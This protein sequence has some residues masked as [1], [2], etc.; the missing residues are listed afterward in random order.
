VGTRVGRPLPRLLGLLAAALTLAAAAALPANADAVPSKTGGTRTENGAAVGVG[1][2]T[3]IPKSG[4]KAHRGKGIRSTECR[5]QALDSANPLGAQ[6]PEVTGIRRLDPG[7]NL[8]RSCYNI[9]TGALVEG[10]A[11]YTTPVRNPAEPAVGFDTI[12]LALANIDIDLPVPALSPPAVTLPNFDT[13]LWVDGQADQTA[14]AAAGGVTVTVTG[15]VVSTTYL[16]NPAADGTR[17]RDDGRVISCDGPGTPYDLA[18]ADRSQSSD[19]AH[20][21]A[22]PTRSFTIDVTSTWRLAW[23]ATDGSGGDLGAIDRTTTVP[24]R[25]QAKSTA[26][27]TR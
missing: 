15:E 6:G 24:Y 16:I 25:V 18:V 7:I 23:T 27:R 19:C 3:A 9:A 4:R 2:Q 8:W 12:E 26:I 11:L 10:P 17:S 5:F 22:A 21:F 1:S 13:W 14:S 20:S